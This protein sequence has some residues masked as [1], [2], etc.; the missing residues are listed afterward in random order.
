MEIPV[1]QERATWDS[2]LV[3]VRTVQDRRRALGLGYK[4]Q[5]VGA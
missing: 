2:M 4:A 5:A 3:G 1:L